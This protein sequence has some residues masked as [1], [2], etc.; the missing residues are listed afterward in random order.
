MN[1]CFG[2]KDY[3]IPDFFQGPSFILFKERSKIKNH[4]YPED[5]PAEDEDF[6]EVAPFPPV[7]PKPETSKK[8]SHRHSDPN[9]GSAKKKAKNEETRPE[10]FDIKAEKK[11]G[12]KFWNE[13][14]ADAN[15]NAS[16]TRKKKSSGQ[17]K[18]VK[19][20]VS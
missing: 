2:Y 6:Y 4:K 9:Q 11:K 8:T 3:K 13:V 16:G 17:S 1:V 15:S 12:N 10:G 14:E 20:S 18:K 5:K 7:K 19:K